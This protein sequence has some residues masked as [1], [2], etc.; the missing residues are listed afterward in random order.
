MLRKGVAPQCI[1]ADRRLGRVTRQQ[2]L[3]LDQDYGDKNISIT[4]AQII[5]ATPARAGLT[6]G[7][8]GILCILSI[9]T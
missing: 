1:P 4:L 8:M 5:P 6:S 2:R 3:D 7:V 9:L